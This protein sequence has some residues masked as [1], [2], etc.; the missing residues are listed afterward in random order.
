M[1]IT[2]LG[3]NARW[4]DQ[5]FGGKR[6]GKSVC[7]QRYGGFGDMLQVSSIL[8]GLKEQ[9]YSV[10]LNVTPKNLELMRHD[11]HIDAAFL[12]TTGQVPNQEL[13]FYWDALSECFDKFIMLSES[14]E[15]ALLALPDRRES[16]WH[17][18]YRRMI[19]GT[20]DYLE[21]THAIADVPLPPRVRFYP[22]NKE[23]E[24]A[25]RYRAKLGG[26]SFVIVWALSGSSVHK[27]WPYLDVIIARLM[28]EYKHVKVVTCGDSLSQILE[29]G[30]D[31]EDRVITKSGKWSIRETL[32]FIEYCDLVIGPETGVLNAASMLGVPTFLML[33]HSGPLNIGG[34]WVNTTVFEPERTPCYP[35]HILH[36]G[37]E[38]CCRD[39]IT[40]TALCAANIDMEKVWSALCREI[41]I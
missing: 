3:A 12:Q 2:Y 20:V 29:V 1:R 15:G 28:T 39:D 11:P 23:K 30:W 10:T 18:V 24:W 17:P 38:L 32:T 8:P 22:S 27:A 34:N 35:C 37:F 41:D 13:G 40:G 31:K 25:R 7:I 26:D 14:V 33:S 5:D 36:K 4:Q 19:M 21:A 16:A 9:G 6:F